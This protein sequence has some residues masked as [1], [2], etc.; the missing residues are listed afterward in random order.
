MEPRADR[1]SPASRA[2]APSGLVTFVFTDG[3]GSTRLLR[4]L[5]DAY[6]DVLDHHHRVLRAAWSRHEGYEFFTE[7]DA[8]GVAFAS[9]DQALAACLDAQWHLQHEPWPTE[10]RMRVR[11][12]V[13]TGLAAPRHGDYIALA[14]HQTARVVAAGHGDQ[15]VLTGDARAAAGPE[16]LAAVRDLGRYRVRD[17]DEPVHLHQLG[18]EGLASGFPAL[19]VPPARLHNLSR[20]AASFV[21]RSSELARLAQL[22]EP[23]CAVTLVGP[24]GVGKT[25]LCSEF[26]LAAVERWN[27]GVWFVDLASVGHGGLVAPATALALGLDTSD[28]DTSHSLLAHLSERSVLLVLDNVEHVVADAARLVSLIGGHSPSTAVLLTSREPLGLRGERVI[29]LEPLPADDAARLFLQRARDAGATEQVP[30]DDPDL[31]NLCRRLDCLPLALEMAAARSTAFSA[32][33]IADAIAE[34]PDRLRSTDPT[35]ARR[36]H[37]VSNLI[38]WS[39]QLLDDQT[40]EVFSRISAFPADFALNGAYALLADVADLAGIE[41]SLYELSRR[42]LL[43][44]DSSTGERRYRMLELVRSHIR[45]GRAADVIHRDELAIADWLLDEFSPL[46]PKTERWPTVAAAELDNI[47]SVAL[48]IRG[49]RPDLSARLMSVLAV[50]HDHCGL[51]SVGIDDLQQFD[52]LLP[53][54]LPD[55]VGLL[56]SLAW[57]QM[58]VD[59]LDDASRS[60]AAAADLSTRAIADPRLGRD[61]VLTV[62]ELALRR[63]RP[64]EALDALS[65]MTVLD[66]P[67]YQH[68]QLWTIIGTARRL[69]GDAPGHLAAS[70]SVVESTWAG[71]STMFIAAALSNLADAYLEIG[72][73]SSAAATQLESLELG[74]Q[75]GSIKQVTFSMLLAAQCAAALDQWE[76]ALWLQRRADIMLTDL[77]IALYSADRASADLTI[78]RAVSALGDDLARRISDDAAGAQM[79]SAVA[80][81]RATL[82]HCASV[83]RPLPLPT[84]PEED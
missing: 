18:G 34:R 60:L 80:H 4:E 12:G 8:F 81:T 29:R 31:L 5:G 21:G 7:G 23:G 74:V 41:D 69:L 24:G 13:H 73:L 1:S 57:L 56:T 2:V 17:F 32:A 6:V 65:Q 55:R 20:P 36:H 83:S 42:S 22:V 63:D 79:E 68:V 62:A 75:V 40:G 35:I 51:P 67:S 33:E 43:S 50:Y 37:S 47:R 78:R 44:I 48:S 15:I 11:M 10:V 25:R 76:D 16:F 58:S 26:A 82:Q 61:L 46:R 30:P 45:S 49:E 59:R 66:L 38:E 14:V 71:G 70:Q 19:R 27:D 52:A 28:A 53:S 64:A 39:T 54:E 9:A 84:R 72:D 3:E 77:D